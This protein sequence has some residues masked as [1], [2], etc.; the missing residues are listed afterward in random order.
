MGMLKR[1]LL[2]I[3]TNILVI[4]TISIITSALGLHSYLTAYGI[5]YVQLAIFCAIWG[6]AGAFISLF[7]SK[8]IAKMAMGVVIIN[9]NNATREERFLL[10]IIYGLAKKL[11]LRKMPEVGIYPSPEVNAF[12]TG[13]TKNSSLVAVSSG[14]LM[15]MNRD[16]IEAVLGHEMSHVANGDMVTMTLIQGIVNAFALFLSRIIAYTIS[17]AMSRDER[18]DISYLTYSL[19]TII[20]DILFTL[21]GTILVAAFSR[22]REYRADAGGAKLVGRDKMIAALKRLQMASGIEDERAPSL[23]ALKISHHSSWMSLFSTHPPL[24]KR[25]TRLEELK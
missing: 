4:A 24:E 11:G 25:I 8:F 13:P 6:T 21:L 1:V 18:G 20:F 9:P 10:E 22:W 5:D 12:A 7:M 14:L 3:A 19:F 16:E 17:V 15:N 2:F 23:A